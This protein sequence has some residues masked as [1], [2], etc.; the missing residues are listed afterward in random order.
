MA[1]TRIILPTAHRGDMMA[2]AAEQQEELRDFLE[3][4]P[5]GARLRP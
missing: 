3:S 2:A 1:Q 5:H 4:A